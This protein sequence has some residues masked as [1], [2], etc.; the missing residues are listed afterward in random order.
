[1][2]NVEKEEIEKKIHSR[3]GAVLQSAITSLVDDVGLLIYRLRNLQ[4][5]NPL[6]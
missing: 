6:D 3:S 1:V 5:K 4:I 2:S